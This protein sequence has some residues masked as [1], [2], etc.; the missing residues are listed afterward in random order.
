MK[1]AFNFRSL[2]RQFFRSMLTTI[3]LLPLCVRIQYVWNNGPNV[4]IDCTIVLQADP[5]QK[6]NFFELNTQL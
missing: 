5:E 2:F 3:G 1:S 4:M 6:E